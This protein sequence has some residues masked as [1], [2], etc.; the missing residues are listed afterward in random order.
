M[1]RRSRLFCLLGS[2]AFAPGAAFLRPCL[3]ARAQSRSS[4][5]YLHP[6]KNRAPSIHKSTLFAQNM[7]HLV[8]K[9]RTSVIPRAFPSAFFLALSAALAKLAFEM[10]Q[11][12]LSVTCSIGTLSLFSVALAICYDN[13]IIGLGGLLFRNRTDTLKSLSYPRF[14]FHFVGVPF[15]YTTTLNIGKAAGDIQCDWIQNTI[16]ALA[17]AISIIS[18]LKFMSSPGIALADTSDWPPNAFGKDQLVWFTYAKQEFLYY[19]F[20]SIVLAVWSILVG[21]TTARWNPA[22]GLWLIASAVSVLIG[23][24]PK[25]H[26]ARF[27]G[28]LVEVAMLWCMF[29]SA[30]LVM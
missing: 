10:H 25:K 17:I 27:T 21:A 18:T 20:P 11:S 14:Y 5:P 7:E 29:R 12:S 4:C 3:S 23:S 19:V 9:R 30:S 8:G 16:I 28:N 1:M 6:S 26:V 15:L 2:S 22:A 24:A 13:F